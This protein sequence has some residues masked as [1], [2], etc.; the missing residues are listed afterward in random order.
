MADVQVNDEEM[1]SSPLASTEALEPTEVEHDTTAIVTDSDP[2]SLPLISEHGNPRF[3]RVLLD[4]GGYEILGMPINKGLPVWVTSVN[5]LE[6]HVSIEAVLLNLVDHA[7]QNKDANWP[8]L[9]RL[10]EWFPNGL[11]DINQQKRQVRWDW[12][13]SKKPVEPLIQTEQFRPVGILMLESMIN[14]IEQHCLNRDV[15]LKS[16]RGSNPIRNT[17]VHGNFQNFVTASIQ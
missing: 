12:I 11:L 7:L 16:V 13:M 3:P 5:A 2:G 6:L 14:Q 9:L 1:S 8:E 10:Y 4:G 17:H 15:K